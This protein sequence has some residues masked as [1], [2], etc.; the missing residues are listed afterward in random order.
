MSMKR[1]AVVVE[2]VEIFVRAR[3]APRSPESTETSDWSGTASSRTV[4]AALP[5]IFSTAKTTVR[6]SVTV[7]PV[8]R[9][10]PGRSAKVE[11]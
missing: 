5:E 8:V 7:M 11:V 9:V 2:S 1:S 6:R 4:P 3:L 10:R